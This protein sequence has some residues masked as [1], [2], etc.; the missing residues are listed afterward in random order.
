MRSKAPRR[1]CG[2]C[3]RSIAVVAG[4][5]ARH[6]PYR[7]PADLTS[8]AGSYQLAPILQDTDRCGTRSLFDLLSEFA[9][10]Q[11]AVTGRRPGLQAALFP[12]C[13]ASR[14]ILAPLVGG[15]VRRPFAGR[16]GRWSVLT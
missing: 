5:F 10:R 1:Y 12:D 6:D 13:D 4:R 7:R 11:D 8:C 14:G 16:R 3:G 2:H 15:A 9:V